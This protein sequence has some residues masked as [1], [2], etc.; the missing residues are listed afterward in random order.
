MYLHCAL[1]D[2]FVAST[3]TTTTSTIAT[4]ISTTAITATTTSTLIAYYF[5]YK[6]Q[7]LHTFFQLKI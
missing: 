5:D 4:A 3:I 2:S 6:T 1:T 7:T